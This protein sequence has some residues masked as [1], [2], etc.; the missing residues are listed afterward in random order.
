MPALNGTFSTPRAV[1][2]AVAIAATANFA[3]ANTLFTELQFNVFRVVIALLGGWAMVRYA[4]AGLRL[5]ALV[6]VLVLLV[7]HLLLK[8]GFFILGQIISPASVA[9][10]GYSSFFGVVLS[11]LMFGPLASL[12]SLAGGV[13][14]RQ[15]LPQ[16]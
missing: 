15:S 12:I 2:A 4:G 1:L 16:D 13:V 6:G 14:A 9:D 8:G 3:I 7:D 10:R 5:A 11:L